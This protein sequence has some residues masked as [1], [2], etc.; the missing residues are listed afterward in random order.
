MPELICM[1][2]GMYVM[3][4]EHTSTA[5]YTRPSHQCMCVVARQ[6]LG[7]NLAD[8]TDK[9]AKTEDLLDACFLC[10]PCHVE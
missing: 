1:K 2:L 7:K 8:A 9:Y 5:Y 3:V 10:G 4:P 6:R